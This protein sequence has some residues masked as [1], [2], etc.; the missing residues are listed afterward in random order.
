MRTLAC[1]SLASYRLPW[2]LHRLERMVEQCG[3][4]LEMPVNIGCLLRCPLVR[5]HAARISHSSRPGAQPVDPCVQ[6]CREQRRLDPVNL[7]RADFIR[8]ED[9][10]RYLS[11]GIRCF[12]LVDRSCSTDALVERVTAYANRRW[13]GDLLELIG[14]R[15]MPPRPRRLPVWDA[16]CQLGLRRAWQELR[17]AK[18]IL[19]PTLPWILDNQAL[20]GVLLPHGCEAT[21]C[22]PCGHCSRV[23]SLAVRPRPG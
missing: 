17:R 20:A 10:D 11:L 2:S 18:E 16:L 8:P 12:K 4:D 15:G 6:W 13:E 7:V 23:A 9:L 1:A 21:D 19:D 22:E 3:A 5:T 14:P